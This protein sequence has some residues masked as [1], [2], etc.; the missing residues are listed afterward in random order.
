MIGAGI[1]R[2]FGTQ[3]NATWKP[4]TESGTLIIVYFQ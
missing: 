4:L 3:H 1:V 2:F